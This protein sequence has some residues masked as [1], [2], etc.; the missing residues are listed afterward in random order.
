MMAV[1]NDIAY[2]QVFVQPLMNYGR[3]P[4]TWPSASAARAT[5]ANVINAIDWANRHGLVT[6]SPT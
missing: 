5:V 1:A 2:D 3:P 6:Y 4:A